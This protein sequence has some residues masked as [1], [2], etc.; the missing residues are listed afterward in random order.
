[1]IRKGTYTDIDKILEVTKSCALHLIDA[2]IYQWNEHYPNKEAFTEDV[3]RDELYV[4]LENSTLV[5]CICISTLMDAFYEPLKWL[6]P[7]K[8]NL[9]IHRLAVHP[10]CQG[11][12]YAQRLMSFA[13]AYAKENRFNSIRL[14][15]FSQ[16]LRNMK[17]YEQRGYE[18]L[19]LIYFP[20]QSEYPFYCYEFIV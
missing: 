4:L 10:K 13:E 2:K 9:Y 11:K 3:N 12:G 1:M 19:G 16:N 18:R 8:N 15:T 14:D 5:G 6:T 7:N 17:F 20:K